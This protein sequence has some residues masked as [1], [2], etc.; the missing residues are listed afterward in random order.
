MATVYSSVAPI[1]G[2][3]YIGQPYGNPSGSYTCGFH[4]GIDFPRKSG[5]FFRFVF[6]L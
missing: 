2:T 6:M 4:T 1:H 5:K 3:S